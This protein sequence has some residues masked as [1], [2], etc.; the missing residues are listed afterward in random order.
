MTLFSPAVRL[1]NRLRFAQKFLLIGVIAMFATAVVLVQLFSSIVG[2]LR[3]TER[4]LAGLEAVRPVVRLIN[5]LQQHRGLS[6]GVINGN[7]EL[8]PRR[9]Q[10]E[11]DVAEALARVAAALPPDLT[12]DRRWTEAT[13]AW[14]ALRKDGLELTAGNNFDEHSKIIR[15]MLQRIGE[16]ADRY[17]MTSDPQVTTL[18]LLDTAVDRLPGALEQLAQLRGKG[19]GYLSRKAI[20]DQQKVEF[21]SML[22]SLQSSLQGLRNNID[23]LAVDSPDV[24][25]AL[26]GPVDDFLRSS[27]EIEKIAASDIM[28]AVFGTPAKDYFDKATLVIEKGYR[29][30]DETVTGLARTELTA[31]S[32]RLRAQLWTEVAIVVGLYALVAYLTAGVYLA[33][34]GSVRHLDDASRRM[35]EGDLT[36][37]VTIPSRDELRQVG[38][39]FNA[40]ADAFA[41]LIGKVKTGTDEVLGASARLNDAARQASSSS[42]QQ[43][44]AASSMA[45]AV[46]QMTVSVDHIAQSAED[47]RR[48]TESAGEQSRQG[49]RSVAAVVGEMDQIA[50]SVRDSAR[51]IEDLGT[52]SEKITSIVGVIRE[53]ADQTNLLAL[54]AAIEAARAGEAGRGFAVV[55]D[56]V[57]KL[58]ERTAA[59]TREIAG[60][61]EAIQKGTGATVA[62][63]RNGVSRVESGVGIARQAGE[64]MR[65]VESGS[66]HVVETVVDISSA[67]REQSA[68]SEEL[69]KDVERIAL[70]TE[71]TS[72]SVAANAATA[73]ELQRLAAGLQ[74]EV[75]RFRV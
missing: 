5:D 23:R 17:S 47:A 46:E 25:A 36:A 19:T 12:A 64:A 40:M 31:R 7:G 38:T 16:L 63:M 26:R 55:A 60:M 49:S 75:G 68:A 51:M 72:S 59:S 28:F 57:R 41:L 48:A 2:N 15:T 65:Q 3:A 33:I 9:E 44:A 50:S 27:D 53:I 13:K 10:K 29:L 20:V 32:A 35:A 30:L 21:G 37:R 4:E 24:A 73:D 71:E 61:V 14:D 54:N 11:K 42:E 45:A 74:A 34:A 8:A 6:N 62:S 67:L 1:M 22:G 70:M 43:A 69:A 58:A 56:E 18:Y 66:V 52:Q 39:S